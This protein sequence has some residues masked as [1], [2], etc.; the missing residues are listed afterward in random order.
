MFNQDY[1]S[2]AEFIYRV[3]QVSA[4]A[5]PEMRLHVSAPGASQ[6][7]IAYVIEE[8]RKAGIRHL[9]VEGDATPDPKFNWGWF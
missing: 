1:V 4:H 3:R 6:G 2:L 7:A 5:D 9:T 8:A